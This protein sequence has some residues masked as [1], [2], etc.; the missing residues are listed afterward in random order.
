MKRWAQWL[1]AV[2]GG[3]ADRDPDRRAYRRSALRIGLRVAVVSAALVFAVIVLVVVYL[4]WQLTPG[5]QLE[6]HGPE[7]VH[8]YLD[9]FDLIIAVLTVGSVAVVL[10]GAATWLIAGRAVRPLAEAYRLQRTFVADASHELRTPLTV[11]SARVQQLQAMLAAA[12]PERR[13]ADALRD[14]TR[15]LVDVVEDLL[16]TTAGR[17]DE[18][19]EAALGN[20]LAVAADDMAV[21]AREHQVHL[22]VAPGDAL[23]RVTPTQLLRCLV[24]LIDNAIGHSPTGG[25]VWVENETVGDRVVIRVRDEGQGITGIA[26][27]R[28]FD[29]FAHGAPAAS[30][31]PT[32]TSNGIGLSLVRDIAVRAGGDVEVERTG[33]AGTVFALSLPVVRHDSPAGARRV[34]RGVRA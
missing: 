27:K 12:T 14:D 25:A 19:A 22:A 11:L 30:G 26:P 34:R 4:V 2:V 5:Q 31:T 10:A 28:V 16:A 24:A 8:V 13:V 20:A 33:R 17:T 15:A 23:V 21:L 6:R 7:D 9:T 29:R 32:R 1:S 18:R 3:A